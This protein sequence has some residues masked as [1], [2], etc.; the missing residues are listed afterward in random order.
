METKQ[1]ERTVV[2]PAASPL[3]RADMAA[4]LRCPRCKGTLAWNDAS[5]ACAHCELTFSMRPGNLPI[6]DL[7]VDETP[8][9]PGRDPHQ[10]W[11]RPEFE[12]S[13][14]TIGYHESGIE[15]DR[16]LGYPAEVSQFLFDRVKRRMVKWVKPGPGHT[17]LDIGCGAGYFLNLIRGVYHAK[18]FEPTVVGADISAY[19]VSYMAERMRREGI[20]RVI[21]VTGNGEYLPFADESFDLVTCSEVIEHIQN[22]RRALTE[23][24]RVLKPDGMLLLSTPSMSAQKGWGYVLLPATAL[25]KAITRYRPK[26]SG[27]GSYDVPWYSKEFQNM[28]RSADIRIHEFE[29]NAVIPHPWHFIF[30]PRPLVKPTVSAFAFI[31]RF[32]KRPFRPLALHF[33]VRASRALAIAVLGAMALTAACAVAPAKSVAQEYEEGWLNQNYF[34]AARSEFS[35]DLLANVERNHFAQGNFWAKYK[36]GDL[37]R[38]LGDL[39]YAL[40]VFPNHPKAL[41]M[42]TLIC[43]TQKDATTPIMYFEKAVRLFPDVAYTQAQYGAYLLSTGETSAAIPRIKEALKLDPN[44]PYALALL[45]EAQE[46]QA[47][48]TGSAT[49]PATPAAP[50]TGSVAAPPPT[51]GSTPKS[52]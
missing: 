19:Q 26:P 16:A 22:P 5:P 1:D 28:I 43:K 20:P 40:L 35:L 25:V 50:G 42:M 13:Y 21:A 6:Y 17:I 3:T 52:H 51:S 49:T 37:D 2:S 10:V 4:L 31:D 7:Y 29:Y 48:S 14:E 34:E 12:H 39:K 45:A 44:M 11:Q 36:A 24:R 33:V 9:D 47:P 32:L 46:K 38:A 15:F 8:T 18:G 30:L 41:H 23:M 27:R